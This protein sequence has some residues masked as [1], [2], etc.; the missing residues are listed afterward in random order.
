[1]CADRVKSVEVKIVVVS[2]TLSWSIYLEILKDGQS[3][4]IL[5]SGEYN[6]CES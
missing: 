1:M 4:I 2:G 6:Y 5:V 3:C